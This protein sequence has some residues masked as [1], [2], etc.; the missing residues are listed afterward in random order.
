M[1][2]LLRVDFLIHS[3]ISKMRDIS[4]Q[5]NDHFFTNYLILKHFKSWH[6][7]CLLSEN[8]NPRSMSA[9]GHHNSGKYGKSIS[10]TI[11]HDKTFPAK[12]LTS[13]FYTVHP[14]DRQIFLDAVL[15]YMRT[16]NKPKGCAYYIFS[17][18]LTD[19]NT[20]H[21]AAA[22][23]DRSD[24]KRHRQLAAFLVMQ[25]TILGNV[26]ILNRQAVCYETAQQWPDDLLTRDQAVRY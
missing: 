10:D 19:S 18:D 11:N 22:W 25:G 8:S 7:I 17:Q 5:R 13:A 20:F 16:A 15:S 3:D 21:L 12:I 4:Q 23:Q 24:H 1:T 2:H 14:D 26:R 9:K 6:L